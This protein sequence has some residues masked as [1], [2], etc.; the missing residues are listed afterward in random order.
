M[1]VA[2]NRICTCC[3]DKTEFSSFSISA[4]LTTR[5]ASTIAA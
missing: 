4:A 2:I 1:Q 3:N 5:D